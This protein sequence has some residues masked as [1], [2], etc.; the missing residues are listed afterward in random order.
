[1]SRKRLKVLAGVALIFLG[2]TLNYRVIG[3]IF[4]REGPALRKIAKL[5]IS[6]VDVGSILTG[7]FLLSFRNR[8]I[9]FAEA[10]LF[11]FNIAVFLVIPY[12][13]MEGL[14]IRLNI[15]HPPRFKERHRL[16]YEFLEPDSDLGY[17]M[18]SNLSNFKIEW[19][20]GLSAIYETD[21]DGFRNVGDKRN[22]PLAIVGD[23]VAF[24]VGVD[25]NKTWFNLL[26]RKLD[27]AVANYA[28]GGYHP[29]QYNEIIRKF[30]LERPHRILFYCIFAND[31]S[32]HHRIIHNKRRYYEYMGWSDYKSGY[33]WLKRTVTYTAL[34][35]LDQAM[36]RV[37]QYKRERVRIKN[38]I[39]L[40]RSTGAEP[41]Y[42]ERRTDLI[43]EHFLRETIRLT[44]GRMQLIIIL[45]PSKESVYREA[46]YKAF[47]DFGEK[48]LRNEI[49]GYRR[50]V[51]FCEERKIPVYDLTDKL[52]EVKEAILFFNEDP[53]LNERGN[54]EVAKILSE[55]FREW[56]NMGLIK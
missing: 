9:T 56:Q 42:L 15:I 43:T 28:V 53:H 55:K 41:D 39:Y 38:G 37:F 35:K 2:I 52:R 47:P 49:E 16:F 5:I 44:A 31:L 22:A 36:E 10:R 17:K 8:K 46:Y 12:I 27:I 48:Y 32:N 51:T 23:S 11:L 20:E 4:F 18:K 19:L 7:S 54:L 6:L 34:K 21:K 33:P 50:I 24:G 1:M 40:Y 3:F 13:A 45:F 29:W 14:V 26:S 30:I 25:Y